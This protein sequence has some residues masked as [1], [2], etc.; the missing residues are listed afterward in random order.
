MID[1][2]VSALSIVNLD[3]KLDKT[4]IIVACEDLSV[5][6]LKFQSSQY[7]F[8]TIDNAQQIFV[9]FDHSDLTLAVL[10]NKKDDSAEQVIEVK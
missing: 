5:H 4:I 2:R 8:N 6:L 9:C 7:L 3:Q 10:L 1:K